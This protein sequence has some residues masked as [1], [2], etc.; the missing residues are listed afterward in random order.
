MIRRANPQGQP[1]ASSGLR[2]L[3]SRTRQTLRRLRH[4]VIRTVGKRLPF[5]VFDPAYREGLHGAP[6]DPLRGEKILAF[7][8]MERLLSARELSR[9]L[10][11]AM[12]NL[13]L[14]HA[15]TYLESLQR[16]E[17]LTR[18]LGTPLS[19]GQE[20]KVLQLQ[21]LMAGGT[22]QA[23]RLVGTGAPFA[24]H[25]GGGLHHAG[26]SN[27]AGFC[28][29][30]D[31]AIAILRLRQRGFSGR[32]LVVDLDLHDGN[33]TREIFARDP[34]VFTLSIHNRH[35]G[36]VEAE[37]SL[38]VELGDGVE[39][40]RYLAAVESGLAQALASFSPSLAFYL[41]GADV[42]A[43]DP[44]GNW[45]ITPEGVFLRDRMV[46]S[47]LREL[48]VPTVMVLAGGYGDRA[49]RYPARTLAWVLAGEPLEPPSDEVVALARLRQI[50]QLFG[51]ADE[52]EN[53]WGLTEEDLFGVLPGV[54]VESRF[55]G[56]FSPVTV[57]LMLER[58]G[59]LQQIRARGFPCPTVSLELDHP[60]GH[61][62]R[63]FGDP[64]K[65]E[66]LLELRL[67]RSSRALPGFEVL[68]VEWLLLQNP[69]AQF[70]PDR[71]RLPGQQHPGLGLLAEVF[72][73]LVVLCEELA[74]D[75]LYFRPSHF[76]LAALARRHATFLHPQ[77]AAL[78]AALSELLAGLSLPEASRAVHEGRVV[79][80]V[81]GK[82]VV[83]E[84]FPMVV[85]V[86]QNLKEQVEGAKYRA[87]MQAAR[88]ALQL[89]VAGAEAS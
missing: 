83:W 59:F 34:T 35:W 61:T 47:R 3:G 7:L 31:V 63:I 76:H 25:L 28:L 73:W 46:L 16:P 71:P 30:N 67:A 33:G 24:V 37:A 19:K 89:T 77:H 87:E 2:I 40:D 58:M 66:L 48:R 14:A 72:A 26:R 22:I 4:T 80:R 27:G 6:L 88:A 17:T 42:A 9:P 65:T 15:P 86:S 21:R 45:K 68:S 41:A 8:R 53:D 56:S 13:L 79:D 36:N 18:I 5:V 57:E 12:K 74:L 23:T 70:T 82:P 60:L 20:E 32:V 51:D 38:A 54:P 84:A 85:P 52:K 64:N 1:R 39:D 11:A 29:L 78:F 55:L 49:W 62:L 75:G 44:L 81:T 50:P 10:P 69:R 43:D